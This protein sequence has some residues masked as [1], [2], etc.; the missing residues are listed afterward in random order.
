MRVISVGFGLGSGVMQ[1]VAV[2]EVLH[3]AIGTL[4]DVCDLI[5]VNEL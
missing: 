2:L 1:T 3:G 5:G 4:F